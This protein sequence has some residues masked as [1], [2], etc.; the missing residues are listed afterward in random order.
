MQAGI[1]LVVDDDH[2]ITTM[3]AD[4]LTDEGYRV[5]ICH[6]GA[7]A[8]EAIMCEQPLLIILDVAMPVMFGD[9]LLRRLRQSGL[10]TLPIIMMTAGLRTEQLLDAGA[11]EVM[12]KPFDINMLLDRVAHYVAA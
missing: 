3:L 5:H 6:D 11:N 8:Y 9:E 12:P 10:N 7:S 1:I 2:A 4:A